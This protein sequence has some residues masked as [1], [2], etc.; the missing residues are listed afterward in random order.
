MFLYAQKKAREKITGFFITD[1]PA[2]SA[3][4][5]ICSAQVLPLLVANS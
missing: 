4:T 2:Y 1:A 3:T 5:A